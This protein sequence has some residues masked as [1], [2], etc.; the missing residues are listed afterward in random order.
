MP[1]SPA[2]NLVSNLPQAQAIHYVKTF[3]ENLK[4]ETPFVRQ[5]TRMELPENS[6]NQVRLFMYTPLGGNANQSAEGTVGSG[7]TMAVQTVNALMG[8]YSN[9][10]NFS[11]FAVAT[12]I[13]PLVDNVQKELGYQVGQSLSLIIRTIVD[14]SAY[15]ID[16]SVRI[17][18]GATSTSSYTTLT[19]TQLRS[20]VMSL[21]GRSVKPLDGRGL[22]G[23]VIHPFVLGDIQPNGSAWGEPH[24]LNSLLLAWTLRREQ[25][26][27][28]YWDR[29][30]LSEGTPPRGDAIVRSRAKMKHERLAEMTNPADY[31]V[32]N[33]WLADTSN[34][35]PIDILKHTPEGFQKLED[36]GS[37]D[38]AEVV[39]FPSTDVLFCKSPLVYLTPSSPGYNPGTGAISGL[40]AI[41]TYIFG[42]DAV[43]AI[44][45]GAKG[46]TPFGDGSYQN[47]QCNVV[48]NAPTSQAD[49][50]GLIPA[51]TS[52]RLHFTGSLP[53][54]TTMRLRYIDG[55]SGIS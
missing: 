2:A 42:R 17:L 10:V 32:R 47:I 45:L 53:P 30:R 24:C 18:L 49:P 7:E 40:S 1:Y 27:T 4:A 15:A 31:S 48:R 46:D 29:E 54:D 3:I 50:A 44:R 13:D 34:N 38:L 5:C 20:A 55:A 23:G 21:L 51:W 52:Y 9:Y 19:N 36:L 41:R 22:M 39:Q 26:G 33:N 43:I 35:S 6:G 28:L 25:G 14:T 12:A 16:N 37:T 8:E 11:S